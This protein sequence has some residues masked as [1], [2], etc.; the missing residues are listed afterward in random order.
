MKA[1]H[2]DGERALTIQSCFKR[3]KLLTLA[4]HNFP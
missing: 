3:K 4:F 1:F 2:R